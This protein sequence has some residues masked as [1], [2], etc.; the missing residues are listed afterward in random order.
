MKILVGAKKVVDPNI[1]VRVNADNSDVDIEHSK[2]SLNPFDENAIEEALRLKESGIAT[3][4]VALSIGDKKCVEILRTALA[5]GAD[6][7]ILVETEN[8]LEPLTIAKVFKQIVLREKPDLILLG[9]QAIDDDS[10]Q[11]APMLASLLDYP[12]STC[13]SKLEIIGNKIKTRREVDVGV[14]YLE[15]TLPAVISADLQLNQPRFVKLP[16]LMLARKKS[17][18]QIS[19]DELAIPVRGVNRVLKAIDGEIKKDCQMLDNVA[20]I[21]E[22]LRNKMGRVG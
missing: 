3:E 14:E 1:K 12:Q 20:G 18:E 22:I 21:L 7:A 4:V 10:A 5:R 19:F 8:A 15:L 13:V 6:R 11:V 16:Q 17:I 9:K 2:M